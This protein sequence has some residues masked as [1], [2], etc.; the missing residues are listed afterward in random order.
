MDIQ[1]LPNNQIKCTFT[2]DE[3]LYNY[4][5][6]T[7]LPKDEFRKAFQENIH[8][9]AT[10][11]LEELDIKIEDELKI[12]AKMVPGKN[13]DIDVYISFLSEDELFSPASTINVLSKLFEKIM[14]AQGS[15]APQIDTKPKSAENLAKVFKTSKSEMLFEKV[16]IYKFK[17]FKKV[18]EFVNILGDL[19]LDASLYKSNDNYFLRLSKT[20][21]GIETAASEYFAITEID[22]TFLKEHAEI[23]IKKDTIKTILSFN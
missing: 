4:G 9:I 17:N 19:K 20:N 15:I 13:D 5:I 23:I 1:R 2:K 21:D 12:S 7:S 6:D 10:D 18:L 16:V 3:L 22:D 8:N 14:Q 11:I